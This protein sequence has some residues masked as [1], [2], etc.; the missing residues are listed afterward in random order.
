[1]TWA[2]LGTLTPNLLDW[3]TLNAPAE[4]ELFRA[5]QSWVGESPGTGY[6]RLRLLYADAETY[7]DGYFESKRLYASQDEQLLVLPFSPILAEAGYNVRYF[8]ARLNLRARPYATA[9][10]QLT[11]EQF[12]S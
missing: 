10:W 12:L 6:I 1:M 3:Q 5:R 2:P 9:N 7:E 4:G 8:Q 11:L